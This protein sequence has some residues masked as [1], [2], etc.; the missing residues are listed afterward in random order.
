MDNEKVTVQQL[1]ERMEREKER[2]AAYISGF[3]I[4]VTVVLW[5]AQIVQHF[6]AKEK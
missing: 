4:G 2:R 3:F 6:A 5:I 1:A